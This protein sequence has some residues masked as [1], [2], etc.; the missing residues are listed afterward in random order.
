[1]KEINNKEYA[2]NLA[3]ILK[4][5]FDSKNDLLCKL[6]AN[7]GD[8]DHGITIKR[9]MKTVFKNISATDDFDC[10][11]DVYKSIGISM[12]KTMGG[13]SGPIF[14]TFFI[15]TS[16]ELL[17][18]KDNKDITIKTVQ[19]IYNKTLEALIDLSESSIGDKTMI[20]SVSMA[21]N[22]L[23]DEVKNNNCNSVGDA[24]V[25]AADGARKGA[26]DTIMMVAKKGRARFLADKS[27]GVIDAGS[28]SFYIIARAMADAWNLSGAQIN[29]EILYEIDFI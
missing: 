19:D 10:L 5:E 17:S 16:I 8:G 22:H 1:M 28:V 26:I 3:L 18:I 29:N 24:W 13:A 15:Q 23:C 6:D 12:L 21:Y 25:C 14:S 4:R 9:G 11:S 20:D 2:N 27:V 7:L